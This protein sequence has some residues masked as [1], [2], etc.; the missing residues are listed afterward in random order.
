VLRSTDVALG[1]P[2]PQPGRPSRTSGRAITSGSSGIARPV[3]HVLEEVNAGLPLQVI[4]DEDQ[5]AMAR[6]ASRAFRMAQNASRRQPAARPSTAAA[7]GS[8]SSIE[9][10]S[11]VHCVPSA[12]MSGH[13]VDH[14]HRKQ[15]PAATVAG[16]W[17]VD[18]LADEA[19]RRRPRRVR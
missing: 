19:R 14:R 8:G 3:R 1:L 6:V 2:F 5:R 13:H 11:T 17:R 12:S 9:T 16:P 18:D 4:D 7:R 10:P 15:R